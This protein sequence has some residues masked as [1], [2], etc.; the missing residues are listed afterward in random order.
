MHLKYY[1][2]TQLFIFLFLVGIL[3][4]CGGPTMK[5]ANEA[6]EKKEFAKAAEMYDVIAS[7]SSESKEVRQTAAFRGAESYRL[8]HESKSALKLYSKAIKYGA[9]DPIVMYRLAQMH[10]QNG[11]YQEAIEAFKKYQKEVPGDERI[12]PM[13]KGCEAAL[14]WKDEPTRYTV[15]EFKPA[16]DKSADDFSPMWA[17]R[18]I[19]LSCLL[20]IEKVVK[21]KK[22]IIPPAETTQMFGKLL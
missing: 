19:K 8:I 12:E 1:N 6:M 17:D 22:F 3:S 16:N 14:K 5:K 4:S 20:Q 7:S 15:D 18:K 13:I 21:A 11:Q 10:K 9:K 2:S